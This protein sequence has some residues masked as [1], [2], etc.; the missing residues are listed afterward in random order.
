MEDVDVVRECDSNG[1]SGDDVGVG[2]ELLGGMRRKVDDL[3]V[4]WP[5]SSAGCVDGV[6]GRELGPAP[7]LLVSFV[8]PPTIGVSGAEDDNWKGMVLSPR[9]KECNGYSE[10]L[11]ETPLAVG[12]GCPFEGGSETP[13]EE[14]CCVFSGVEI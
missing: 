10:E 8:T 3:R 5:G 4:A 14:R 1:R 13:F 11:D 7:I 12:G 9:D 6:E 2:L